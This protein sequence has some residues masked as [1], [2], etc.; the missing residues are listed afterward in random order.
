[1]ANVTCISNGLGCWA[2][3][4]HHAHHVRILRVTA[5]V[6][7]TTP[8]NCIYD[9]KRSRAEDFWTVTAD[10]DGPLEFG[11]RSPRRGV[12]TEG[13]RL[14]DCSYVCWLSCLQ[15]MQAAAAEGAQHPAISFDR[16]DHE[17][18]RVIGQPLSDIRRSTIEPC[19]TPNECVP[20][21]IAHVSN[22][23]WK[24]CIDGEL[25]SLITRPISNM[26]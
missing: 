22:N 11:S 21:S 13:L 26:Q 9:L 18:M 17:R 14:A 19:P 6:Q 10:S 3:S 25:A 7:T 16:F 1:M 4:P 15:R 23:A 20:Y 8:R 12:P 24:S 2:M 5:I